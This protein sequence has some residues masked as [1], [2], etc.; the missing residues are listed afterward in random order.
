MGQLTRAQILAQAMA[1]AGN[2]SLSSYLIPELNLWMRKVATDGPW[3][4]L[5]KRMENV[6]LAAGA[7]FVAITAGDTLG[8]GTLIQR[9]FD[10][11]YVRTADYR[12]RAVA[13]IREITDG[14]VEFDESNI[15]V[16]HTASVGVPTWFKVMPE[17]TYFGR[18]NLYPYPLAD[19]NYLLSFNYIV[20]P[21]DFPID[22]TGDG[23][24]PIYPN[25]DTIIHAMFCSALQYLKRPEFPTEFSTLGGKIMTD[26]ARY[27]QTPGIN[28]NLGLDKGVFR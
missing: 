26:K 11:I 16:A 19:R 13:R 4:W 6:A 28:D 17:G 10:P 15:D 12:T 1:R 2:T 27:I 23:L 25:D 22:S 20:L 7:P 14:P 8:V 21:A 9:L 3:P 5:Q 24:R 18:W